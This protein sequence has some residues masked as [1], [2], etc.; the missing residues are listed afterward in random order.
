MCGTQ[1]FRSGGLHWQVLVGGGGESEGRAS[2]SLTE[3]LD[4]T[5]ERNVGLGEGGQVGSTE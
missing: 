1:G 3:V 5:I 4:L 2:S